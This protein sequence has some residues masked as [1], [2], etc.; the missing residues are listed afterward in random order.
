MNMDNLTEQVL[1][2]YGGIQSNSLVDLLTPDR[3]SNDDSNFV[4]KDSRYYDPEYFDSSMEVHKNNLNILSLNC[5]SLRAKIDNIRILIENCNANANVIDL[6]V[7]QE[8][9]LNDTEDIGWLD[10]PGFTL[11]SKAKY[12]SNHGGL[13]IYVNE[14][15][16]YK[17][18][19]T[20]NS[21]IY[22]HQLFI[23]DAPGCNQPFIVGNVYR[24]PR[25]FAENYEQFNMEC[26]EMLRKINS[27]GY[28]TILCGDFNINL[29]HVKTKSAVNEF[30]EIFM[31]NGYVPS[32]TLP[33]RF[34][35]SHNSCSLLDNCFIKMTSALDTVRSCILLANISDHLP[36]FVSSKIKWHK[37]NKKFITLV[38]NS[39][40]DFQKAKVELANV[41][42]NVILDMSDLGDANSN[43]DKVDATLSCLY[44]RFLQ[45]KTVKFQK[46]KHRNSK[47]VT[48]EI[49]QSIKY[50]DKLYREYKCTA[51]GT[52]EHANAKNQVRAY[53]HILRKQI[54]HA[55]RVYNNRLFQSC[56]GNIRDTWKNIKDVMGI[57]STSKVLP[58][59]FKV[60]DRT[61]SN[62]DTIAQEF[63]NFFANI[64]DRDS[65]AHFNEVM[66]SQYLG[67][68]PVTVFKFKPVTL[69]EVVQII[70]DLK[71]KD[72]TGC[73]NISTRM[74]QKFSSELSL[75]L[76]IILNQCITSGI[77][78]AKLKIGKVVPIY[79][80]KD[81]EVFDNYRPITLLPAISKIFERAICN[82]IYEYMI[83]NNLI[84]SNQYGFI[85]NHSTQLATTELIDRILCHLEN[86]KTPF[87]V[88]LDLSKAFDV[89]RHDILLYK[90]KHYGFDNLAL[91][92]CGNYLSGRKQY[93]TFEGHDS[94][95]LDITSGVPQGSIVGPLFFVIF[96]NDITSASSLFHPILYA[97][98]TS[99]ISTYDEFESIGPV[100][101]ISNAINREIKHITDWLDYNCL[102]LNVTKTKFMHFKPRQKIIGHVPHIIINNVHIEHVSDFNFLGIVVDQHITW[103]QHHLYI[104]IKIAK[105]IGVLRRLR[106]LLDIDILKCIYNALINPHL[107]YGAIAW[108]FNASL[109]GQIQ[110]KA[111]RIVCKTKYNAHT[112]PLFKELKILK[113]VDIV[114]LQVHKLYFKYTNKTLPTYFYVSDIIRV[115]DANDHRYRTRYA[116]NTLLI[117]YYPRL[118]LSKYSLKFQMACIINSSPPQITE[119]V[120]THSLEG[121]SSYIKNLYLQGYET[122]CTIHDCYICN[123]L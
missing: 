19:S 4:S 83:S 113:F 87:C 64:S 123:R 66:I 16:T 67:N 89:I 112:E 122:I 82:Q 120:A 58:E 118:E 47:W 21:N 96:I 81:P 65:Q 28:P 3:D 79:K 62:K 86:D 117:E 8:T 74:L 27:L 114:K 85:K 68:K 43:F 73:D 53:N 72:S 39:Y 35:E 12:V 91:K 50:R 13:A 34:A 109:I 42:W 56:N 17:E 77:F 110:K 29:L 6:I 71:T 2:N 105:V 111:I 102:K 46:Y 9:W 115:N 22:E 38:K 51:I 33:T 49:L 80:K 45:P 31:S 76:M 44:K 97:D 24:P 75:P 15:I 90:L 70:G 60:N 23:F 106:N 30:L 88:F 93:V 48:R 37:N 54:R 94:G 32:I 101:D 26:S 57:S 119:K 78:P 59:Q 92:L 14:L 55:K 18:I 108:G 1:A 84:C 95:L 100:N 11:L 121:F 103:K 25:E 116:I 41:D 10:I 107:H 5:Q 98:D 63:N 99:L 52:Y 104:N 40:E 36:Y 20:Q 69:D 61:I 7:L